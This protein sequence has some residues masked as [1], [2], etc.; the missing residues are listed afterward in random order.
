M[1]IPA[2][3]ELALQT[4]SLTRNESVDI[5]FRKVLLREGSFWLPVSKP[6]LVFVDTV[7]DLKVNGSVRALPVAVLAKECSC[8]R[9]TPGRLAFP[10]CRGRNTNDGS[11]PAVKVP[12]CPE[13]GDGTELPA[14]S[15]ATSGAEMVGE[16][17][18]DFDGETGHGAIC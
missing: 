7:L 8:D 13:V 14:A 3:S 11:H 12:L 1:G 4:L 15:E 17:C 10:S 9:G 18:G 16:I 5:A 6:I 2:L